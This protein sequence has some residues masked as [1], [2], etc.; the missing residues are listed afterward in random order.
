DDEKYTMRVGE[1]LD[2][3]EGFALTPKQIDVEGDK[4]WLELTKDGK[5]L[6]DDVYDATPGEDTNPDNKSWDYEAEVAG[7][8]DIVVLRVHVNE[9]FQGQ[10]DSLAIIEGIWLM[11]DEAMEIED[12]EEFGKM[13]VTSGDADLTLISTEDITLDVGDEIEVTDTISIMVADDDNDYLRFYFF[14]EVSEPGTYEVRG[15]VAEPNAAVEPFEW[16][17][18]NFAGLVYDLDDNN[19]YETLTITVEAD[20]TTI[21]EETGVLY[22]T[23]ISSVAYEYDG[24]AGETFD[25]IGFFANEYVPVDGDAQLLSTLILDDDEK[26]T[27][28]VGETLDLGEGFALTPKQIDV[29]GDKVWLE[30]TK[31]GKFL[32]DDVYD[33]TPGEDTNPDNKS[34]DYEAEVAGEDDIV[35]L[36]VHVNEVFQGQ[37]D[38]LAIIE[39]IWLMSD[40]AM[41]IE[42]D[43]EFGEME[44]TT[45]AADLTLYNTDEISLDADDVIGLS[46]GMKIQTNDYSSVGG[47]DIDVRFYPFVEMTIEDEDGVTPEDVTPEDVTPEDVTPEDVT[48]EDV[49]PEN[50]TP[51]NVTPEDVTPVEE[52]GDE[53]ED[54]PGFE[55]VFAIAGLL[56]VAFFVRRN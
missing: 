41:E 34:W 33:A 18:E 39:G 46:N 55:A 52:D 30:L 6:D 23:N 22:E 8:D 35:V 24:W 9:V 2:L 14:E 51:E 7:E 15:S 53:D 49:T 43:E 36:R 29:E 31:D 17:P 5:F 56:A 26:Y 38:S 27:M 20:N 11:S 48:P 44:V 45:G 3:G 40:E 10:V 1:T 12:D 25:K 19:Q 4:V 47:N 28:R 32:D 13:E 16:T 54:V 50:V 37:V 21:K 42:D